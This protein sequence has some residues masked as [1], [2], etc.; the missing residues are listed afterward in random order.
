[1]EQTVELL[2][3]L[4]QFDTTTAQSNLGLIDF[5]VDWLRGHGITST[6][7]HDETGR[8][9][10]LYATIGRPDRPG[11]CLS[12][13]S[14]V[15]PVTGQDWH[16]DPFQLVEREGRLYGRGTADMKGFLA[17][18]LASV[19]VFLE[20]G[21]GIPIHLAISYDEEIGCVGVRRLLEQL[22]RSQVRP[23][24]CIIGEPTSM[25][26]AV[27]HKGKRAW[28][29]CVRGRAG[30][31]A[32]THLGVNA[33]EYGAEL[34]A[35]LREVG[36]QL[37]LGEG[38]DPRFE[39]PYTTVHTGRI[40][41]GIALNVI[42]ETCRI[43]FEMRN[44]PGDDP[45]A[46]FDQVR[47]YA[48]DRLEPEMRAVDPAAGFDWQDLAA[49]PALERTPGG[50]WLRQLAGDLLGNHET[51]TLSFGTEGGLFQAIG[52]PAIVCGPGSMDQGHKA[53]EFV[54]R[55]QLQACLDFLRRLVEVMAR[56]AGRI[57]RASVG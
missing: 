22:T 38:H 28:R 24:A 4:V 14:D 13:H 47:A 56:D 57:P 44:L 39:P 23:L 30:H 54:D 19:P 35:H 9:A 46:L 11:I 25:R 5:V 2:R 53:D 26:L 3:S 55:S 32:L 7:V 50:D 33:V 18:M 52:I 40:E 37:R 42:P 15:V 34:V 10:N 41:G 1:M 49:Y 48:R 51:R 6:L 31:S 27:A 21:G 45:Q 12:G 8:K 36:R 20:Y 16:T 43:D 17:A 29:C